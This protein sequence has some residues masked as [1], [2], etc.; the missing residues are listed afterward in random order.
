MA[1]KDP[2]AGFEEVPSEDW[3][4]FEP[5]QAG[6]GQQSWAGWGADIG[7]SAI[8]G[9]GQGVAGLA[10]LPRTLQDAVGAG[11]D[12]AGAP[13]V[14]TS[15][16]PIGLPSYGDITQ[17]IGADYEPK[18][19]TG[20]YAQTAASFLPSAAIGP[21]AGLGGRAAMA[22]AAGL[23]SEGAGQAAE[24]LGAG[25][26]GQTAARIGASL[27]T[28][29]AIRGV[30]RAITPFPRDPNAPTAVARQM[31]A[32]DKLKDAGYPVSAGERTGSPKLQAM[33]TKAAGT[34]EGSVLSRAIAR[35]EKFTADVMKRLDP[36]MTHATP[37]NIKMVEDS[38]RQAAKESTKGVI[39]RTNPA[40]RR[41][42][43][44]IA[45][46][47]N[48]GA[49]LRLS[50]AS[51][52]LEVNKAAETLH[53]VVE[54]P[55][56]DV[57]N[58]RDFLT[59]SA[60]KYRGSDKAASRAFYGLRDALDRA[61]IKSAREQGK[62]NIPAFLKTKDDWHLLEDVRRSANE[63]TGRVDPTKFNQRL[64]KFAPK[65]GSSRDF[66]DLPQSMIDALSRKPNNIPATKSHSMLPYLGGTAGA[67]VGGGMA[68]G[69][70]HIAGYF[71]GQSAT[72]QAL[73]A[74]PRL[75]MSGPMQGY[76]GNQLIPRGPEAGLTDFLRAG[77]R[78]RQAGEQ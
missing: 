78:A 42:V 7:K 51:S 37:E 45:E 4:G 33:E 58:W 62:G 54:Q 44:A 27:A 8:S 39:L 52:R 16:N 13:P 48:Q 29:S 26:A 61:L 1:K 41:D 43:A 23:A 19:Q 71:A 76:L 30:G 65:P 56:K 74:I 17:G 12:M 31:R 70:G 32:S 35:E 50:G 57:N 72:R 6:A 24:G 67:A 28:P 64:T 66:A 47:Y 60:F 59:E 46:R 22:G 5:A 15:P 11:F 69:I 21:A 36:S 53:S 63:F 20:R 75:G 9:L 25:P 40:L 49:Q 3:R 55:W 73:D 77:T 38:L 34:A 14:A 2:W 68:P 18:S 10:S